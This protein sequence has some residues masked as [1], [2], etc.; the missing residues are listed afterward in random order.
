MIF[1]PTGLEGA[2]LIEPERLDDERGYFARTWCAREFAQHGLDTNLVQCGVAHNRHRGTLRGMHYQRPPHE[3]CKL[4]RCTRGA[5]YDVIVDLRPESSTR[6][7]WKGFELSVD[8]G[9]MLYVPG[10]FAHGYLTLADA[11][12]VFYQ[13]SAFHHAESEAGMR[14]DDPAFAI[15]WPMDT[16]AVISQRDRDFLPYDASVA[17]AAPNEGS[18]S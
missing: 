6:G 3:E 17:F 7:C 16:P 9:N 10:G 2:Y 18:D 15:Q 8:N 11:T 13:M 5:V 4:V 1:T 12:D 14:W